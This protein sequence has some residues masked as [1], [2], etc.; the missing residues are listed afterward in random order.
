EVAF[1]QEIVL[2]GSRIDL[3]NLPDGD[4]IVG[5][6]IGPA[7]LA[8]HHDEN[9]L[10]ESPPPRRAILARRAGEESRYVIAEAH[11]RR[12][13]VAV[14]AIVARTVGPL[15]AALP[16]GPCFTLGTR[17]ALRTRL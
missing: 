14:A 15:G 7:E 6:V 3:R 17:L 2:P 5:N 16:R 11:R 4:G 8:L 12:R 10:H 9:G 1:H 13:V